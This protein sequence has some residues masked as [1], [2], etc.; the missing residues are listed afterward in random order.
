VSA[1][2]D[3]EWVERRTLLLLHEESLNEHGGLRGL[4]DEGLLD[5]ALAR[6]QHILNYKNDATL[7]EL[8]AAYAVGIAR[9][10]PFNDGNKRAALLVTGLFLRLHGY[11]LNVTQ[12]DA[13][14]AMLAVAAGEMQEEELAAWIAA[15]LKKM[16]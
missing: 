5:S 14:L 2:F 16:E 12:Q 8:T 15:N 10:H 7:A 13:V 4:R 3:F 1:I 9:N 11:R 6:P